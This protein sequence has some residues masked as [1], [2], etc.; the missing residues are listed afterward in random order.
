[1]SLNAINGL[2]LAFS[3]RE[4]GRIHT[5]AGNP[6][7]LLKYALDPHHR[8]NNTRRLI[9][10]FSVDVPEV[11]DADFRGRVEEEVLLVVGVV[12]TT[13]LLER[14]QELLQNR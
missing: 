8:V 6:A 3:A 12:D 14:G 7:Y 1:M 13:T 5:Q 9:A 2:P 10:K 4:T 11:G